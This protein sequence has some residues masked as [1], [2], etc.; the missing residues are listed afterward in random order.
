MNPSFPFIAAPFE[1]FEKF[2]A[3]VTSLGLENDFELKCTSLDW[4]YFKTKCSNIVEKLP[5]LTFH[6]G[7]GL[8]RA[9]F[10]MTADNYVFS[11]SNPKKKIENCHLAIIGQD[12]SNVNYWILGDIFNYNFYTSFN[13][14][15]EPK[16]GLAL[17]VDAAVGAT[18]QPTPLVDFDDGKTKSGSKTL[19]NIF[20][21]VSV[22]FIA[23]LLLY[24]L[25]KCRQKSKHE[26]A[27]KRVA[28]YEQRKKMEED[29]D[30]TESSGSNEDDD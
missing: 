2:K 19:L 5:D 1:D 11:E 28:L 9:K 24:V 8:Q 22:A 30:Y 26:A 3:I 4:C 14:E 10:T 27:V 17:Q 29:G 15:N 18:I 21:I 23:T 13:A 12:F 20:V 6:L 16:I 25:C 7:S